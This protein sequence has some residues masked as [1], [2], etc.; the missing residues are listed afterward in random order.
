MRFKLGD[1]NIIYTYDTQDLNII[2][3]ISYSDMFPFFKALLPLQHIRYYFNQPTPYHWT[4]T[5]SILY[6][7][8]YIFFRKTV[9]TATIHGRCLI[10]FA[11]SANNTSKRCVFVIYRHK[12]KCTSLIL[13]LLWFGLSHRYNIQ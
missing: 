12:G 8:Q 11:Y 4:L 3:I 9:K 5:L 6:Y 1:S 10:Y 2:F 7:F 13:I